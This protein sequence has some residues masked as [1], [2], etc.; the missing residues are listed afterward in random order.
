MSSV[1][2]VDAIQNT[3]GAAPTATDLGLD[4]NGNVV[5]FKTATHT[6]QLLT[7]SSTYATLPGLSIT[8]TPKY[9]TS[10]LFITFSCHV[11]IQQ[12]ALNWQAA[13]MKLFKDGTAIS[14]DGP[15]GIGAN[16]DHSQDRFMDYLYKDTVHVPG[17]TTAATYDVRG[18]AVTISANNF[19]F[20]TSYGGGGRLSIME[21][22]Q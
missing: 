3:A 2:K 6:G 12:S 19:Q 11:F 14:T 17:S 4:T 8:F 16:H 10:F 20:N 7:S 9:S 21:I 5:Q 15:Y 1:L 22:A 18:A 13:D